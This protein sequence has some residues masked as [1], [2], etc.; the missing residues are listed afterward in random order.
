VLS[1]EVLEPPFGAPAPPF[2]EF[3][4][5]PVPLPVPLSLL[6]MVV[7][8]V[9]ELDGLSLFEL[10]LELLSS[11]QAERVIAAAKAQLKTMLFLKWILI[12][13]PSKMFA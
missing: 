6:L 12:V 4:S 2:P 7:S 5:L 10:G 13:K 3:L 8:P 11:P 9:L 1:F